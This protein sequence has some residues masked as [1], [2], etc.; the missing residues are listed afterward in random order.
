MSSSGDLSHCR[1]P[2]PPIRLAGGSWGLSKG[3]TADPFGMV[4]Q[5]REGRRWA[6][7]RNHGDPPVLGA[8][9]KTRAAHQ[10]T[11]GGDP[12]D[13]GEASRARRER[14]PSPI[15][16][17]IPLIPRSPRPLRVLLDMR[18][19][20]EGRMRCES[21]TKRDRLRPAWSSVEQLHPNGLDQGG[22]AAGGRER[23]ERR[24]RPMLS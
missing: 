21:E 19:V 12:H 13:P 20:G 11:T 4:H 1:S 7:A 3:S 6:P 18:P 10:G 22:P 8:V 14:P 24:E 5:R 15:N 23:R 17:G 9:N 16:V 2:H